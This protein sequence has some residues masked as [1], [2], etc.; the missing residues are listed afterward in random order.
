MGDKYWAMEI[1]MAQRN[2]DLD[3]IPC[4]KILSFKSKTQHNFP[5]FGGN[6]NRISKY[7][8]VKVINHLTFLKLV[9]PNI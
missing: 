1:T 2:I 8:P 7:T 3:W 4:D 9:R 5:Q 6:S